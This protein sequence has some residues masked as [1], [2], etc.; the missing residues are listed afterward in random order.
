MAY[1]AGEG[2]KEEEEEERRRRRHD[3][4]SE[5]DLVG[6][7]ILYTHEIM[8]QPLWLLHCMWLLGACTRS[9]SSR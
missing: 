4:R 9:T 7:W 2:V 1:G 8:K 5:A 3:E 6:V